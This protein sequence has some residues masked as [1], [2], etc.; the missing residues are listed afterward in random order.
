MPSPHAT[1]AAAMDGK[2]VYAVSNT[3]VAKLD[4]KSGKELAL[5]TGE[6]AHLNSALVIE[7][8]IYCAHSNFPRKPEQGDIRVLDPETMAL[9]IFHRFE[10]PPGSLTWVLRRDGNWWCHFAHYGLETEKARLL[11]YDDQWKET[12][13]WEYPPELVKEWGVSSLSGAIWQ[14]DVLLATGHD[15]KKIYRLKVPAEGKT[16]QW[17]DTLKSPFPGQG[18]AVNFKTGGLVGIDRKRK[19]VLFAEKAE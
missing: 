3:T 2:F 14:G 9:T 5:S 19:C 15:E 10:N 8:K 4:G 11:R 13:R 16:V 7:G 18:I 12:G 17:V 6:A 1:Q